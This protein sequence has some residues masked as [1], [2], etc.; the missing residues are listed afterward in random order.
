MEA[1][2]KI[3]EFERFGSVLGLERMNVLMEK[4]GNPQDKLKVIHVAGTN[5]KG[6]IC[7]YIYEVLQAAGYRTGLYTSPFLEVFNE[8]IEFDGSYISDADLDTYT[9]RVLEKTKEM[10]SE[11]LDSPTEFEVITAIAFLYFMEKKADYVVL[12]VGLGGRGDSTNVVKQ[13]LISVI[14]SISLDHTDRLGDTISKI[15]FEKAGIIKAGCPVVTSTDKEDAKEV[16][17]KKASEVSADIYDSSL[18]T[19]DIKAQTL[20]GCIF[21]TEIFG[22]RYEIEISMIGRHQVQN[23]MA[24]LMAIAVMNREGKISVSDEAI[25]AGFRKAVQIGRFE[26]MEREPYVIIDGAHNPDGS[27]ALKE[28]VL[29]FF[30]GK[31][32]LMTVGILA[33]KDVDDVLDNFLMISKEFVVTEPANPRKMKAAE[34]AEKISTKGGNC[35]I[36]ESPADAVKYAEKVKNGYDLELYAGSLYLIGEIRGLL[37]NVREQKED[38]TLL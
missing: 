2:N 14:A 10:V 7:K 36:M 6:S 4:L 12:E 26:I 32:I 20:A 22:R 19:A 18:L 16:F 8:R 23:A 21:E 11:G 5:G 35:I 1:I 13:P 30:A 17:R 25:A 37:R 24:A 9:A 38:N 27:R 29:G 15:A 28:A 31:K 33:D 34:L 3:H